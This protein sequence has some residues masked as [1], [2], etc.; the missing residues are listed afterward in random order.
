MRADQLAASEA[1]SP[2]PLYERTSPLL[3]ADHE[4]IV[5]PEL[6]SMPQIP[7]REA[8]EAGFISSTAPEVPSEPALTQE[9]LDHI[10][11]IQKLA[12]ETALTFQPPPR[13]PPPSASVEELRRDSIAAKELDYREELRQESRDESEATSGA[14]QLAA[15]EAG[16]PVPLYERTSPLLEADHE[17]I[18]EPELPS[19]PQIP[20][21]EAGEAGVISSS[22]PEVPSEPALTQEELDHIAYIQKLAEETALTFQPPPRPPPPSASVEELRRDSIAAKE[23]DYR[24]ELRQES[25][26][27]SEATSGA[28]Q[29]AASEAGSPVPL[30]ERT[31]PLLEADHEE[32]V[33]PELPSMPQ[34][35]PR[36]A[37][38]AGVISSTA[39]EVPSEPALTQ[40]EL[41]HIAYI[42]K[43]AEETALTFQPPPRPPPP[44]ASVE[45][46]R[47][48]SIAAKELD[49]REELRQESRDESEATSGA[50]QLAAS[51]AG[52]P[53]PL[54]ERTSPLLEADHEEIVEPELPSMPQIPPREAVEAGVISSTAPEVPSEP[55]LT[56]EELDHIAYIQKLAEETALTF[57][58]PPR[59]PPPS[60]SVEELRRD[61]IAAKELDYREELRQ[62]SRDESEATSGADQLAASEAGS[63]VPLYERT[64]PLLE[65]DH[66]EIVEPE[67]PSMPQIP[68][69][70]AVEAGVIS[71][72]VP[73]V[74]SEPALTQ[75][76]LDHIAYIQKLAE[77]TAL[78]FQPP[79]RPPPPSASVEE[80]RRDSIAAKELDY[81]EELRQESRDESEATSGADQ[82]AA[83]EAGSP[84]PLYERTSPLLEA[85]H[86]EIVEPEL[87]SMP[88][89]PPREAGEAGVISSSVPEVPSE[90]ALT[91][92][93][94]DHI[95]YIQKL[96]EETALTFQ[97]PPRPPPPSASK[98]AEETALTFQPPP[99]PPPPS[100]SVEELRRDSIAAKELDYREELRQESRDESEATSGADQLAASEAGSP[101]P[102]YERTS[103]LLE[104]DHEE[105]VE[106]ELPSM[107]QIPPREAGEAG[108]ISSTAPEVPSEP[109][110]T[111]EELDHIA[112]IQKLAE[113]TA[114]TFQPPPR[115]PPP[116]ASVE[117]L[118]RDS[119]AAKELDYREELRQESRD[120]SEATSGADQLAASEAGSPVPLYERTSPLL[121]AD[122]EEIV[123]PELPSMPQIPPREAGEAGVISSTAPEVPSEPALT[124]EELDHIAY[125]QKLAEETALTFQPP[126][127]PPPPSASVEE[128]RRDSIAAKELDYREELRQESRDESEATSGADQLAASEAGSPVPLY[129]RTSPLLEADHEE[130]VEP[131][132]PSMPQIPPREAG[133]AG[134]ISSTAPEVPSE[135]ALTQEELDH[136]AYIQ[137]LAEET[138]LTFQPPPRPPPPSASVEELRRDSIAAK[139]LDYREELRQESRDE[140][141][142]TSGADQLAASEAGSPVPLYERTSPL[143]EADH[144]EI[145]EPEL[146]SMPQIP[147][148]EAGEAGFISSTAPEVP[149]EPALTQEELDHIAYIQKLAEET[150]LTFQPPPRPP[151]PSASVEELRRDSIAAKELD[152]REELRQESRDESEATSG[153]DQL[154]ASEAGSPVPLYE[155]TSPLLEADHEEIV[156]PELPSMPQIPPRE[157]GEAGF[158]SSTAPEV[159]SEPAL[160]QEELD[161]IAYIQKLAEETALTVP[162]A[163]LCIRCTGRR[164]RTKEEFGPPCYAAELESIES[165]EFSEAISDEDQVEVSG[166]GSPVLLYE[167]TS[168]S[169]HAGHE[170]IVEGELP[171]RSALTREW[172][173]TSEVIPGMD[174][175]YGVYHDSSPSRENTDYARHEPHIRSLTIPE[176]VDSGD[177]FHVA[178]DVSWLETL[179]ATETESEESIKPRGLETTTEKPASLCTNL[180]S[181]REGIEQVSKFDSHQL[182]DFTLSPVHGIPSFAASSLSS[183]VGYTVLTHE[184][185]KVPADSYNELT[186]EDVAEVKTSQAEEDREEY[187]YWDSAYKA[188]GLE[189]RG[190]Y[191][192]EHHCVELGRELSSEQ[193]PLA[194]AV[195]EGDRCRDPQRPYEELSATPQPA[196]ITKGTGA[197]HQGG[198]MTQEELDHIAYIQRLAEETSFAAE[199]SPQ[200]TLAAEGTGAMDQGGE[201]TQE[202]L[203]HIAYIQR[204]AEESS[205]TFQPAPQ[206]TAVEELRKDLFSAEDTDLPRYAA[207][208]ESEESREA[209][210][211]TSGA[212]QDLPSDA[213]SPLPLYERTSPQLEEQEQ[214][215]AAEPFVDAVHEETIRPE[216]PSR[217]LPSWSAEEI[218]IAVSKA[219]EVPSEP[220]LTQEELDHIAYIQRL[221]EETSFAAEPSPQPTLAAEGTGAMDQGGELTQEELDHIA[222][223]QR[224]AEES[225]LTFQP[226]PQPTAVEE[227]RKDL[228]SAEDTD[229]PRY[230]AE[231]E[232]EESREASEAT[233]GADQDLPSDAGSPLPL[234]ERTSP[235]L[236][237]QEQPIA[238]EPFVDAVHEETIRPE[239]PSRPLPSWSAEE[240]DIAVSKAAEVP[241]EPML[242]QE[243]L[244][245]IAYIQRLAEETSFA[246]EPSPQ[247]TLAAEGTG[248]MDQGGEL[249]QEELDHIAYIQR[250]AEESSLTFQPAP[251]PTA[252]E[253]LRKDLFSAE[254]T[255]LPRYA[256]ELESEESRE[257]SEATSGADQDLPSDAGSPLPVMNEN[258]STFTSDLEP[259]WQ[260]SDTTWPISGANAPPLFPEMPRTERPTNSAFADR[261][262]QV[263]SSKGDKVS[264][265]YSS[266]SSPGSSKQAHM[267]GSKSNSYTK[268][269]GSE[270]IPQGSEEVPVGPGETSR[271]SR[272]NSQGSSQSSG[273]ESRASTQFDNSSQFADRSAYLNGE[274]RRARFRRRYT[275]VSGVNDIEKRDGLSR[276]TSI[277]YTSNIPRTLLRHS[278]FVSPR[279][280]VKSNTS[281][282]GTDPSSR[283][284][285][286]ISQRGSNV[287]VIYTD[288]SLRASQSSQP[289][290]PS[291]SI[292]LENTPLGDQS[293]DG[294][295]QYISKPWPEIGVTVDSTESS[296][297]RVLRRSLSEVAQEGN[298][299][300]SP[301]TIRFSLSSN[302]VANICSQR[303]AFLN[304][305][306]LCEQ[307]SFTDSKD[308]L[309]NVDFLCRLNFAAHRITE[310]IADEAGRDL[311]LHFRA[312][313]NPRARYFTDSSLTRHSTS[314]S[315][316][317]D[318]QSNGLQLLCIKF[319]H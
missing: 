46:L 205:L 17:E 180:E 74:P 253:E 8:G 242:T 219:A 144:E 142:A 135:P 314:V 189:Q 71:S 95:A 42:Q 181:L 199:P 73:E 246:A 76:E 306:E 202:E 177:T 133:E 186:D 183:M 240:I 57:Q 210:E 25:R 290:S 309:C 203:D 179:V 312:Q 35:P 289:D 201:L 223:I 23:L 98:L 315:S 160:T 222:Y 92:E 125:I 118:R 124:Q 91:Q 159:P 26:D 214:P 166:D 178:A 218:D 140:S 62:E 64:S 6:P 44:S 271:G 308:L 53:V 233:S 61:S 130:I 148:R 241:S 176:L 106:P 188:A 127:R 39:P 234:Y 301:D 198:E 58:P 169:L 292:P 316:F 204:L 24:E 291:T 37:V 190:S 128:L 294:S 70:E 244:D 113:E 269:T 56:Q 137:K 9:E 175:A 287:R 162:T 87:P 52:S 28:D 16:S 120:E 99:R 206:P 286:A 161:H 54:Y 149:S 151:P 101:V 311:R 114:L 196:L 36:E 89:I 257:A 102:L 85:D 184:R 104:A 132:L 119:I 7:P 13:P 72:S 126:P 191:D 77:E 134:F 121:E 272:E 60:A 41:D 304:A 228:F 207:E 261:L 197:L 282:V 174:A 84:V 146:P 288:H 303:H 307:H 165:R 215:I 136:I 12:E 141:E 75:E 172:D 231:L 313:A 55:A 31:S 258:I 235:Q 86:E 249:T 217:P 164:E 68:P 300:L 5:E 247:P 170:E 4:E 305:Y 107:P 250:L 278:S 212:D 193:S 227:L 30:Y 48:D 139:E 14:D 152:Y 239:I 262:P 232:S 15:S 274:N 319:V 108:V 259:T 129:E 195:R 109:A 238:A 221:A 63:P 47:R 116:S 192:T 317:D 224:L 50:D 115:P 265:S 283:Q 3:E 194:W 268:N 264:S 226:A 273:G 10:A 147:P 245:H 237:E 82:L 254:D 211:A 185:H 302:C 81:R 34:I 310:D 131:E 281:E 263:T 94:L 225:S 251:Q 100:A 279:R 298:E 93:E 83:S 29:L 243:E 156:E 270:N 97:P 1:G 110:L 157:A 138:A 277:N 143:L 236:E 276:S 182:E 213:G 123:E 65:A 209:S 32:I 318:D 252:V 2:V 297:G 220:M 11:Y 293:D 27:E 216:I 150:A 66:E 296:N 208:L 117:E 153:A 96:A 168:P 154:A 22:V 111:Q 69:R 103:P 167:P 59:P 18:V 45:E 275:S 171:S 285:R 187:A 33:E 38:E 112:Y 255:D 90:P 43:L 145:V 284:E 78:T 88:Q 280:N 200:P 105:I 21:R 158:I 260:F 295:V 155:R 49:Y 266:C 40:E 229:L 230:A 248:A 20:P 299:P 67:L 79:P 256:A 19:M 51:E 267:E 122:H 80:L 173:G 163:T